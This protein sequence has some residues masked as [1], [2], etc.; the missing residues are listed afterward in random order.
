MLS[1]YN[2]H[3]IENLRTIDFQM[4]NRSKYESSESCTSGIKY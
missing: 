4:S 2:S 3:K 1:Y